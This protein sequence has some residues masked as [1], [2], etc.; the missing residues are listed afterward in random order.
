MA[1]ASDSE[2]NEEVKRIFEWFWRLLGI[3]EM[4]D[5]RYEEYRKD[6]EV[7]QRARRQAQDEVVAEV[8]AEGGAVT[9]LDRV[10]ERRDAIFARWR[11]E[12]VE[13][14]LKP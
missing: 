2:L 12:G 4:D 1:R 6:A 13:G 11:A 10:D 7:R 5:T 14:L 9:F 8:I 3:T